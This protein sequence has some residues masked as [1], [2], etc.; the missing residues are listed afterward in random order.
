MRFFPHIHPFSKEALLPFRQC[1]F[2]CPFDVLSKKEKEKRK[3]KRKERT[4]EKKRRK[5][6]EKERTHTQ[7]RIEI[8]RGVQGGKE[9]K[10]DMQMLKTICP[11]CG[12]SKPQG[13]RCSCQAGRNRDYDREHRDKSAAAFYHS[14]AWTKTQRAVRAR[15]GGCDEYLRM[16][17]GR[18]V[19]GSI[20][21]HIETLQD[22]PA[23]RL[24]TDNL[25]LV[26]PKTHKMIHDRYAMGKNDKTA[27]QEALKAAVRRS[28]FWE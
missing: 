20:V 4:K 27:M 19:P 16:T 23:D 22:S 12:K 21:H 3:K 18:L 10:G 28:H 13:V 1:L 26:C 9:G 7:Q 15:A 8:D 2:V 6:K 24:N 17:E 25:I 11:S 14:P 5:I